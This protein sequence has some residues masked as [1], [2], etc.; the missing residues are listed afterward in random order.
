MIKPIE[1]DPVRD[2][3]EVVTEFFGT[4]TPLRQAAAV[5]GRPYERRAQQATMAERVAE[6]LAEGRHLCVEAPTGVGKTFAYLVPAIHLALAQQRPVVVSTHTISLQEQILRRDFP[7]LRRLMGVDVEAAIAKGRTNYLC[8]RRLEDVAGPHQEYLPSEELVPELGRIR[9]W[10]CNTGDGSRSDLDWTPDPAIWEAVCC[11]IGNC[12]NARC[13]YF[14]QCFFMKARQRLEQVQIIVANHAV[15]FSDMALKLQ[16]EYGDAGILPLY[17]AV[18]LDEGHTIEDTAGS[19]M[20]V[21]L[22]AFALRRILRRLYNPERGRGLL[23]GGEAGEAR[24]AVAEALE[25]TERFFDRVTEWLEQIGR[26]PFRYTK[27]GHVPDLLGP[28]LYNVEKAVAQLAEDEEDEGRRQE[29]KSLRQRTRDFRF[30]LQLFLEMKEPEYV[31]WFDM[32]GNGRH[33]SM[34]AVPVEI[35]PL[36]AKCLFDEDFTVVVTSA[37]LA[38]RGKMEYF[39]SRIGA[40]AADALVLDTPFDFERQV[41]LYIPRKM[42]NPNDAGYVEAAS[43]YV[44]QFVRQ[45][46]GKAFVL[47]TSYRMMREMAA[48]LQP[49]FDDLGIRL[50]VQGQGMPRSRMLDTFREDVDS[51]IFGTSSFWMGVDV[52]G[53]ALSNVIIVRLPFAVPDHPL[54]AARQELIEERGGKAFF[55]Y[56]LPEAVLRFRQGIGR[57]IRSRDDRGI[58]VILDN[59]VIKT[60]YGKTFLKSIPDCDPE[61]C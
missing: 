8:L 45:T 9:Q 5:G 52:P 11:E 43:V 6:A 26:H 61:L 28:H 40:G 58:I 3:V 50:L 21:R 27:P 36:L 15:F 44:R 48:E 55:E 2:L 49:F 12:L 1:P 37:T 17:A 47:F 19:H 34:N 25:H 33:L 53:E 57:L 23:A 31:Y 42:P 13:P 59:R 7:V 46:G 20:G 60:G 24:I 30:G 29:L 16:T 35:G 18:I 56:T 32:H 4:E 38:V 54:V 39:Q 14:R 10:A 22:T 41:K 51:V